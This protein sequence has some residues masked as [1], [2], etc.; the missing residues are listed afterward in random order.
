MHCLANLSK[1][2]RFAFG[3]QDRGGHNVSELAYT[4]VHFMRKSFKGG[5]RQWVKLVRTM[6]LA[7]GFAEAEIPMVEELLKRLVPPDLPHVRSLPFARSPFVSDRPI[8][9]NARPN[10][11]GNTLAKDRACGGMASQAVRCGVWLH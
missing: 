2:I 10:L 3:S 9:P 1:Y 6:L 8:Q 11:V 7:K 5:A 4:T